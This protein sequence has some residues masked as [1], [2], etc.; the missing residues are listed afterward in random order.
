MFRTIAR[1]QARF[2]HAVTSALD[3]LVSSGTM[4]LV[5]AAVLFTASKTQFAVYS[6]AVSY[7]VMGQA[8]LSAMFGAPLI[9]LL[10][11]CRDTVERDRLSRWILRLQLALAVLLG[12]IGLAIGESLGLAATV[13]IPATLAFVG[14]SF[15][16]ALRNCLAVRLE[17]AVALRLAIAFSIV[18]AIALAGL[19][20]HYHAIGATWGLAALAAGSIVTLGPQIAETLRA[21]ARAS[22][23]AVTS[24]LGMA[25]WTIPGAVVSWLQNSFYLTLVAINLNLG[26]VGEVSKARMAVMPLLIVTGGVMRLVQVSAARRLRRSPPASVLA[27]WR[28]PALACI[29]VGGLV[30]VTLMTVA[31]RIDLPWKIADYR[32]LIAL[33]GAWVMF[34]GATI[35]RG[36]VSSLYQAMG[37]FREIFVCNLVLL[38]FV[39]AGV[40]IAPKYVGIVGAVLP[41]AFG[42]MALMAILLML[43]R[44][45]TRMA[46]V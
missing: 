42:E 12:A 28:I 35:S 10:S 2:A 11:D 18:T 45:S 6:L 15:R 36:I 41:M 1:S 34:A 46:R 40:V 22:G 8:V 43:E 32:E 7:V 5:Q 17:F 26:A 27:A 31:P 37:R 9:T 25:I 4:F 14:L 23:Q 30:G 3:P 19:L 44:I 13:T 38:P 21:R 24:L 16:D 33:V 20:L 29:A 39:L